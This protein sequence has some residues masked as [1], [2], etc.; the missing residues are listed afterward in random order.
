MRIQYVGGN[1][2]SETYGGPGVV[3]SNR[4]Y[5]FGGNDSNRFNYVEDRDAAYFLNYKEKGVHHFIEAQDEPAAEPAQVNPPKDEGTGDPKD[6]TD[7]STVPPTE[8][9]AKTLTLTGT[10]PE[11]EAVPTTEVQSD[12]V[13]DA[14][15]SKKVTTFKGNK[16]P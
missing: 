5:Y 16:L 13:E 7:K 6:S 9:D 14:K 2:G 12:L 11:G 1:V 8:T 10:V 3:P 15:P 4:Y